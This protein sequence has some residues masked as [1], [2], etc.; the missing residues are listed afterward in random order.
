MTKKYQFP[1]Q[2][3]LRIK[4]QQQQQADFQLGRL[5]RRIDDVRASR[6]ARQS[7]L[8]DTADFVAGSVRN[9]PRRGLRLNHQHFVER[10]RDAIG[11]ADRRL[12]ELQREYAEGLTSRNVIARDVEA[13][14]TLRDRQIE[15][16]HDRQNRRTL[17]RVDEHVMRSWTAVH[18][19]GVNDG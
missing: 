15:D 11:A 19:R 16:H 3:V 14:Q 12:G 7:Q 4:Q 18:C 10:L 6:D 2:S 17:H 5:R 1:L 9:G 13:L 8:A